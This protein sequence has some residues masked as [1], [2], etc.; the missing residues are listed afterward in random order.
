MVVS[1]HAIF[2]FFPSLRHVLHPRRRRFYFGVITYFVIHSAQSA[3]GLWRRC[4]NVN[5]RACVFVCIWLYRGGGGALGGWGALGARQGSHCQWQPR[6]RVWLSRTRVLGRSQS[7]WPR[8]PSVRLSVCPSA[9]PFVRPS[10][11]SRS[12]TSPSGDA[13]PPL[14]LPS[15]QV[16]RCLFHFIACPP[17]FQQF[18]YLPPQ[19]PPSPLPTPQVVSHCQRLPSLFLSPHSVFW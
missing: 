3:D 12:L 16:L 6:G 10:S 7:S 15:L 19:T 1:F 5:V 9:H 11:T 17:F 4:V 13:D 8:L 18:V 2:Y 14:T